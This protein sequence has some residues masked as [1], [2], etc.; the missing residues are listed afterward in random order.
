[1]SKQDVTYIKID[2]HY[3]EHV[4]REAVPGD[5][6]DA[7]DTDETCVIEGAHVVPEQNTFDFVHVGPIKDPMYLVVV[8]Y[9]TGDSFSTHTGRTA[10]AA[11]V[12]NKTDADTVRQAIRDKS[13][14]D[15]SEKFR[16]RLQNGKKVDI[17]P[18]QW[19]GYFES[20]ESVW[21][22]PVH[23]SL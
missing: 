12:S 16:V 6:W 20:V 13:I 7:D 22:H 10:F 5:E 3:S 11:L 9:Q 1:M 2:A 21:V 17:Y 8:R 19:T 4:T 18:S 23:V 14:A 15:R